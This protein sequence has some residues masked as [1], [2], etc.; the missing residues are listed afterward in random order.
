LLV[1]LSCLVLDWKMS[2]ISSSYIRYADG[3]SRSTQNIA[4]VAWVIFS[5][6]NELVSSGGIF[7]GPATNNIAEYSAVIELMSEASTLGIHHLV[8]RLDSQLVVSQLNSVYSIHHTFGSNSDG[9]FDAIATLYCR[10]ND[11]QQ[12]PSNVISHDV[13]FP[14]P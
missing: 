4:S 6:T 12:T 1:Y 14:T 2:T 10:E 9:A 11:K 7:L 13:A 5:P 3:A 8:V